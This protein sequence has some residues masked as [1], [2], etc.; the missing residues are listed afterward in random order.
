MSKN[1]KK[2]LSEKS[3][4][5]ALGMPDFYKNR[6]Q[7]PAEILKELEAKGLSHRWINYKSFLED[8]NQHE[9]GWELYKKPVGAVS[10][11]NLVNGTSPDG[12]IRR[13]DI[14]LAVRPKE[15]TRQHK[16]HLKDKVDRQ[17]SKKTG[18]GELRSM[19]KQGNLGSRIA[20]DSDSGAE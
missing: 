16:E 5:T 3:T 2:P 15:H 7:V 10:S 14:V 12:I 17:T 19:A 8:G 20:E 4:P 9:W 13:K 18:A 1:G 6:L 11:D